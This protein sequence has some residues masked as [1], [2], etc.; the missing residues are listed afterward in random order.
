MQRGEA[1]HTILFAV[2]QGG[3]GL[4]ALY[5]VATVARALG[6]SVTLVGLGPGAPGAAWWP[7]RGK[8]RGTALEAGAGPCANLSAAERVLGL[9]GVAHDV[10]RHVCSSADDLERIA[11][12]GR[13]DAIAVPGQD[14]D[15][16]EDSFTGS[17]ADHVV[18][19]APTP[20]VIVAR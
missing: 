16:P 17:V 11:R 9:R 3:V 20:T 5:S 2:V 10:V 13:Y 14:A 8:A 6:A 15:G 12:E 18:T 1:M 7:G 19:H 4:R